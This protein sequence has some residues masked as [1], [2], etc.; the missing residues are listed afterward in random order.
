MPTIF[1][2]HLQTLANYSRMIDDGTAAH[3]DFVTL[4]KLGPQI[5]Q[6]H[7]AGQYAYLEYRALTNIYYHLKDSM[8]K[9]LRG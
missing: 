2:E 8:R 4:Q 5:E 9:L 6:A 3:N 1:T 7:Q